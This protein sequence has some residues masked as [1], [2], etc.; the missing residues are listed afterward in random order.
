MNGKTD[1]SVRARAFLSGEALKLEEATALWRQLQSANQI[2]TAR[3]VLARIREA[4]SLLDP[5]S[6]SGAVRH[7][8]LQQEAMLTSK[9]PELSSATRHD[10]AIA[11]L[12]QEFDLNDSSFSDRETLGIAGGI[13]K[14]R[15]FE[16]G[17]L[18]D[19]RC[20]ASFYERGAQAEKA[21][22]DMGG[23]AYA[24]IN[25]AFLYDLLAQ[26]GDEP[27]KNRKEAAALRSSIVEKLPV[28][29]D[30]WWNAATR[31]EALFGLGQYKDATTII[32]DLK[33]PEAWKLEAT[34]RQLATLA[35]L[36]EEYPLRNPD[37]RAFFD[38]LLPNSAEGIRSAFVGKVGLALSGGGFRASFYHLGVLARLA[39][40]DV[41]R[42]VEVLSCV[43]GGSIVG[44]CYWLKLRQRLI[45]SAPLTR[46]SYVEMVKE[47]IE[48]FQH[49][50]ELDVRRSIQ[51]SKMALAWRVL[52]KGA[53][54]ALDPERVAAA[55]EQDFYRPLMPGSGTLEMHELP[56][57]P[58]DH[59][60]ALAGTG[61]F[62]PVQHNW[63]RHDKVPVLILN[64]TTVNTGHGWQFT[65]TWMGESPWAIHS[66]ADSVPRLQWFWYQPDAGWYVSLGRAV[67]ASAS[68]PGVFSP[69]NLQAPYK[70]PELQVQLVD[71][72]VYDNQGTV[73]LLA[74]NCNVLL[75]S[76][77]AGQ[78]LLEL[79]PA[80]GLGGLG[81]YA[82]RSMDTLMERIRQA[83]YGDLSARLMSGL[84]RGLMFVHM[85]AGLDADPIQL[86]FPTE[87]Y[88][89]RRS[90]LSPSGVRKEFQQALAELRTDLDA[91]SADES[92]SLMALGYQM[93][94]KAFARDLSKFKELSDGDET[95]TWSFGDKLTEITSTEASTPGRKTL[96]AALQAGKKVELG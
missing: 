7:K 43:S 1:P 9:D 65:P 34:T 72:G 12:S 69:L 55:L 22:Q 16:L 92:E 42:H 74:S 68:V 29:K 86:D 63:L 75:V 30:D 8:L 39:E 25:A 80:T 58:K 31:A 50:V 37:I 18:A 19:L 27:D 13:Y 10:Q 56:F 90:G 11:L 59:N 95:T 17:Q 41:L 6:L 76:D 51:Q 57:T 40:L 94:A 81:K 23:D 5:Q 62:N 83:N 47:L 3:A 54:G 78:L 26:A 24:H 38:T 61:E 52:V 96:L 66:A 70:D 79:Q 89:I 36:R 4:G 84:L 87:A 82:V 46:N 53:H 14:R 88:T 45:D 60:P 93:T 91:F 20:A 35:Q 77:A 33:P 28:V 64:A 73:S 2:S 48:H 71:G 44:A 49:A 85:K 32:K 15:W 67:A 21:K